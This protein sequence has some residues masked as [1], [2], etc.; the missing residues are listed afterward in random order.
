MKTNHLAAAAAFAAFPPL[1]LAQ[2]NSAPTH[3]AQPDAA[4]LAT[5]ADTGAEPIPPT[6]PFF[7]LELWDATA[8][9]GITG[10][11]GNNDRLNVIAL[12]GIERK[13][14]YME[15]GFGLL[16]TYATEE[17]DETE[18]RFRATAKNDWLL[19]DSKWR[20]YARGL[21]ELD[22]FQ[23]WDY[24]VRLSGGVGYE[25]IDTDETLFV[26][27]AGA[28]V[29]REFG[30]DG[31]RWIPEGNLGYDFEHQLND[32]ASLESVFDY[33]PAFTEISEYRIEFS[34]G[35]K[36]DVSEDGGLYLS[37]GV[38][39]RYDSQPGDGF[40]RNDIDYY[41]TLGAKF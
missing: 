9:L 6:E 4:E 7:K 22:E 27:R 34:A 38:L 40:K 2:A 23:D 28:G 18:N 39:D 37:I 3:T 21:Y 29:L 17:G 24:R 1:A 15:T 41:V 35:L 25:V 36:V 19:P 14:I 8:E 11:S 13:T 12:A 20:Y 33:Y 30:G 31:N 32:R 26:L 16:Y 10:S 5:G